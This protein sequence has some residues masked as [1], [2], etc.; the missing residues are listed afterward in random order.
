MPQDAARR[1]ADEK[2]RPHAAEEMAKLCGVTARIV[3]EANMG[4]VGAIME[5]GSSAQKTLS[6]NLVLNGGKPAICIA[7]PGAGP[8]ATEVSTTV[9]KQRG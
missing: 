4:A 7:E 9:L 3:A 5:Y 2:I 6:A 8:A 1:L